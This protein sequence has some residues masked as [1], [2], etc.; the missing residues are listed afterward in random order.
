MYAEALTESGGT[1]VERYEYAWNVIRRMVLSMRRLPCRCS[2]AVECQRDAFNDL[3]VK[4]MQKYCE[5]ENY[6]LDCDVYH[7]S[8]R[9]AQLC[10][11]AETAR[12]AYLDLFVPLHGKV[13]LRV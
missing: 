5:A 11:N 4:A 7:H 10:A 13:S 6:Q 9:R 2:Q 3:F 12:N 1:I 8:P